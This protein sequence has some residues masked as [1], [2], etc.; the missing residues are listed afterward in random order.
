MIIRGNLIPGHFVSLLY[1]CMYTH[2]STAALRVIMAWVGILADT[3]RDRRIMRGLIL[4][5]SVTWQRSSIGI[6]TSLQGSC[7]Y[8]LKGIISITNKQKI[9]NQIDK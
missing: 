6:T 5:R 9:V 3:S 7:D 2:S 8:S 1:V 4:L